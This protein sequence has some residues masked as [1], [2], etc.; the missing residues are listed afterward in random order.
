MCAKLQICIIETIGGVVSTKFVSRKRII[1]RRKKLRTRGKTISLCDRHR[2]LIKH[3]MT[4]F[5][6]VLRR[7]PASF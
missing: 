6:M 5:Q 3:V 2:D 7:T 4:F 1:I